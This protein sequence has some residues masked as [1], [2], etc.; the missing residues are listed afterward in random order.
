MSKK[1]IIISIISIIVVAG[2]VVGILLFVKAQQTAAPSVDNATTL[3]ADLSKD[4]GACTILD[5]NFVKS[6][7]GEPANDLQGPDNVGRIY[8]PN[9]DESQLC[10]YSFIGGGTID[11]AFNQANGFSTEVYVFKD[12]ANKTAY[13]EVVDLTKGAVKGVGDAAT[14]TYV[15]QDT[16]ASPGSPVFKQTKATLKVYSALKIYT[17]TITQPTESSS[18]DEQSAKDALLTIAKSVTYE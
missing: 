16:A 17:Y 10:V 13:K 14:F 5:K 6:T 11:N 3:K 12:E 7:L 15:T 8:S 4:Y 9:G 1:A 18:F 2:G